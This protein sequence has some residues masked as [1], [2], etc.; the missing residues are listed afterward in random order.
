MTA[1]DY[2][3]MMQQDDATLSA[4]DLIRRYE[5]G[6]GQLQAAVEGMS[7]DQLLARPIPGKWSTIECVGHL[8]DTEIFFTD[9]IIRT[10]VADR[11][12]LVAVDEKWYIEGLRYQAF[13]LNEQLS[14]FA[15]L[16]RHATRI[17]RMQGPDVWSRIGVHSETGPVTLRQLLFQAIRHLDRHLPFIIEKRR[18]LGMTL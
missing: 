14:L 7:S 5:A 11:P 10:I 9:R 12:T 6:I 17:L 15:A 16:R 1:P 4:D 13:D 18:A 3:E 2:M 8:A